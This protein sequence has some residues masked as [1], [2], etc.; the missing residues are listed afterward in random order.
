[1]RNAIQQAQ[2]LGQAIWL[3]YIRRGLLK[4]GELQRLIE[5][6]ISGLTSN[7]TILEKNCLVV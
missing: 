4:S 2:Q 3:D 5:T 7:P 1:M 6:G